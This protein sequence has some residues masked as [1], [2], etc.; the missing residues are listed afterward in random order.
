MMIIVPPVDENDDNDEDD[1]KGEANN[2]N[3]KRRKK[4]KGEMIFRMALRLYYYSVFWYKNLY[5]LYYFDCLLFSTTNC[6]Y[7]LQNDEMIFF[8]L[9]HN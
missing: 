5:T 7:C 2:D 9:T 3:D 6:D 8:S 1:N 4:V